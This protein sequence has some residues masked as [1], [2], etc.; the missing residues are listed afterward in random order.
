MGSKFQ[1]RVLFFFC[2]HEAKAQGELLPSANVRRPSW[3]V[4]S[5]F[6]INLLLNVF[7][8]TT[9]PR[10]LIFNIKHCLV[11]LYQ[12]CSTGD[13]RIPNSIPGLATYF[14]FSFRFLKKGSCHLLAKVCARSTG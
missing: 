12:M 8:E 1:L 5:C 4:W 6:V 14:C 10:A 11:D 13:P 2:S 7:Y 3:V 9:R